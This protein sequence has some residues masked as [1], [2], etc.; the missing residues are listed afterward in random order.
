MNAK[1]KVR[2]NAN[3]AVAR[4]N[5]RLLPGHGSEVAALNAMNDARIHEAPVN[6][7]AM[8]KAIGMLFAAPFIGL[9][10]AVALPFAGIYLLAKL[11]L[12]A[13]ANRAPAASAKMRKAMHVAK[14]IGLF[15]AAPL[16]A[17]GYIVALPM[18]GFFMIARLAMEA[19]A[20]RE[21]AAS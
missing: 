12:E 17:L 14:N 7:L 1:A 10:Y 2:I 15:L 18:V 4:H 8:L 9:A 20:K 19:H 6:K 16:I 21:G 5:H 13:L 3:K 11:A